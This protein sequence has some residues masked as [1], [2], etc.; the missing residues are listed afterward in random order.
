LDKLF[1]LLFFGL[2]PF[3]PPAKI[4][5]IKRFTLKIKGTIMSNLSTARSLIQADLAHARNVLNLWTNQVSELE[6]TLLQI[7]AVGT[8]RSALHVEYRGLK[9]QELAVEKSAPSDAPKRGR[10]PKNANGASGTKSNKAG[11]NISARRSGKLA[12]RSASQEGQVTTA[13]VAKAPKS[14]T[15]KVNAP[16]IAKFKDTNS[17]KTWSGRGRRPLWMSGDPQQYAIGSKNQS[18][19]VDSSATSTH[20][21]TA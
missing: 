4:I 10:K 9:S 17:E 12:E 13:K 20:P 3:G 1:N 7:E 2:R 6:Q 16:A 5:R 21:A 11:L 14:E 19:A 8:S 18:S 15:G